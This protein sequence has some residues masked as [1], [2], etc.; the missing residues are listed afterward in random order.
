[1]RDWSR[2]KHVFKRP[3]ERI[4]RVF[5]ESVLLCDFFPRGKLFTRPSI[6]EDGDECKGENDREGKP[7]H[8]RVRERSPERRCGY[9]RDH[10]DNS[11]DRGEEDG[12]QAYGRCLNDRFA[13]RESFVV[14]A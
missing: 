5:F 1:M 14:V 7:E 6:E 8:D 3:V 13:Q 12:A 4:R 2:I 11:R 10:S 9:E